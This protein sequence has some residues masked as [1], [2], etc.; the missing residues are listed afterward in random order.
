MENS[1][2]VIFDK[3]SDLTPNRNFL[4]GM[5]HRAGLWQRRR[6][7]RRA[8]AGGGT[9]GRAGAGPPSILSLPLSLPP[10]FSTPSLARIPS[11]WLSPISPLA[12]S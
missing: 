10:S 3:G 12:R 4:A 11:P 1:M 6:P 8:G 5:R 2:N 7:D 9:G